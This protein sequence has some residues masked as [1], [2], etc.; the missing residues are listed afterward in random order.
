MKLTGA[1]VVVHTLEKIGVEYI[2]CVPGASIDPILDVLADR[3][4]QLIVCRHEQNAAFMAQAYGSIKGIPGVCLLTAGPGVT[5]AVTGIATALSERKP[6]VVITGQV[7]QRIKFKH[8]HQNIDA[9]Q[10]YQPITKWSVE[11]D[12]K[13]TLPDILS[14]AFQIAATPRMG[15]AHV[16][17][18]SN[19]LKDKTDVDIIEKLHVPNLGMA[20][21]KDLLNA[22]EYIQNA[23]YP[24]MLL[25]NAAS[26]EHVSR[27]IC[28]FLKKHQIPVVGTFEAAG[29]VERDLE[30]LFLGRLGVFK[31]QPG[32]KILDKAD[33]VLTVGF[34]PVEYDPI[35]W[36]YN[37]KRKIIH[38]DFIPAIIDQTYQPV[39]ELVGD[40][41]LNLECID[42]NLHSV[43][44]FDSLP[45]CKEAKAEFNKTIHSGK[46]IVGSPVHPLRLI[47][48]MREMFDDD[49]TIV[50]DVGS[51]QYWMA[52]NFLCFNPKHF[53][54]SMGFQTMGVS[55]PYA[56]GAALARPFQKVVAV[57]GDGSFLM[58]SMDLE[59]A[60][61]LNLP[62]VIMVWEDGSYNL[63]KIQQEL[64]YKRS[65]G[66]AFGNIDI[67]KYANS[68]GIE[69][70]RIDHTDQIKDVLK[71]A[72]LANHPVV[73]SVKIDYSDNHKIVEA[74]T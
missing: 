42:K 26:R 38:I 41:A 32:D 51:H 8:A 67:V 21:E 57:C 65:F 55:I 39:L 11:V 52:R 7:S 36:N 34:D 35:I 3:G 12:Y 74:L 6:V 59:T 46:D 64:K 69:A 18:P 31:N 5:N 40:I 70:Y 48:E 2:F 56:I 28:K 49:V 62:I 71:K 9:V 22:A 23:K 63:V 30:H 37:K 19:I 10:L 44:T 24:M 29:A 13:D 17:I 15:T 50:T 1:E 4:P 43:Q 45:G 16:S 68:F 47:Y 66:V 33:V 73:I 25:G 72:Y 20:I 58:T 27:A 53:L 61:R 14:N 54:T 60:V